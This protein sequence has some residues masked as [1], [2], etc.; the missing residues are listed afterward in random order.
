MT[1]PNMTSVR[2]TILN[3]MVTTFQ[4]MQ[5]DQPTDD[6]YGVTFST[7]ALGP[8][9]DYDQRKRF[10]L[11]IVAG[12]E[13]ETFNIPYVVCW[14]TVNFEFRVT[15]NRDDSAP[16]EMIEQLLTVVKR[17]VTNNRQWGGVAIDTKVTGSEIDLITYAD[18]SAVGVMTAEVQ[19]RYNYN[20]PRNP[21]PA[22]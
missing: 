9:A 14:M 8:L 17:L 16:G 21:L 15:V 19:Y 7:V 1:T 11:G 20:D 4:A 2:L 6:P 13:R 12:P 5:A 18:R 22:I 10:S 3:N